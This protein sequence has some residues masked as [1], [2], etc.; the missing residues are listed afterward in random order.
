[1]RRHLAEARAQRPGDDLTDDLRH[2]LAV[3]SKLPEL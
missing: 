3:Q 2:T 1:M